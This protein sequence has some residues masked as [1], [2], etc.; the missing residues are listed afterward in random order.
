[1]TEQEALKVLTD[2]GYETPVLLKKADHNTLNIEDVQCP[3]CGLQQF[4]IQSIGYRSPGYKYGT[5]TAFFVC[6]NK[7]HRIG[8]EEWIFPT[9]DDHDDRG[10]GHYWV[11]RYKRLG[12]RYLSNKKIIE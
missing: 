3:K 4:A 9:L 7:D 5:E 8:D 10:C 6:S 11:L 1:M 12:N 2:L